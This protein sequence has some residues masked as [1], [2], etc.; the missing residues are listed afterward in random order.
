MT[1]ESQPIEFILLPGSIHD[2]KAFQQMTLQS[3]PRGANIYADKAYNSARYEDL[4]WEEQG[5]ALLSQKKASSR[6]QYPRKIAAYINKKRKKIET[7]FSEMKSWLG[8]KVHA[9]TLKGFK[10]KLTLNVVAFAFK[11]LLA[12]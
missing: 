12:N 1:S 6:R 5:I 2:M 9:V 4:L 7:A 11:T 3:V 10:L 8:Q